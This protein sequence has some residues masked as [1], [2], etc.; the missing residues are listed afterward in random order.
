MIHGFVDVPFG[1]SSGRGMAQYSSSWV[2]PVRLL[3]V[4]E[5]EIR[6]TLLLRVEESRL[7]LVVL[8]LGLRSGVGGR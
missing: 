1:E 7:R 5:C 4:L 2:V 6:V 8:A 3:G